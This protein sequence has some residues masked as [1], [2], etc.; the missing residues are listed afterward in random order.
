MTCQEMA[1][2]ILD[3]IEGNLADVERTTFEKHLSKCPSCIAYVR[4]YK[5][6]QVVLDD[7]CCEC[8]DETPREV[9]EELINAILKARAAAE[10]GDA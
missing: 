9:P 2:F 10:S 3:Y 8:R 4:S 7:L 5:T 1:D 6:T